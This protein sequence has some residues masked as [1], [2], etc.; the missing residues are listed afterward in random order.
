[1]YVTSDSQA[2][3]HHPLT[4]AQLIPQA[5]EES[6]INS[7]PLQNSFCIMSYIMEY[8]F[9]QL[10]LVILI[11]FPLQLLGPFIENCLGSIQHCLVATIN[12]VLSTLFSYNQNIA[13]LG[14][15]SLT[16]IIS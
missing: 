2:I 15:L 14:Q 16:T 4:D 7:H 13:K 11:L 1:M 9:G 10:K 6:D 5:M 8:P 12:N 3:L